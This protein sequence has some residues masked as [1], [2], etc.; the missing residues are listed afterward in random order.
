MAMAH[1]RRQRLSNR[2]LQVKRVHPDALNTCGREHH[3]PPASPLL[4][5]SEI[6]KHFSGFDQ[7][8]V[9]EFDDVQDFLACVVNCGACAELQNASWVCG[10]DGL[11]F[12]LVCVG[13]F[14]GQKI[15][16]GFWLRHVI[17]AGGAA[18]ELGVGDGLRI[19]AQVAE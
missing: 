4:A 2:F 3:A 16:R 6:K 19:I 1:R 13:H 10:E 18:T 7:G 8:A 15:E 14:V 5:A 12:G 11:C 9:E 17:N